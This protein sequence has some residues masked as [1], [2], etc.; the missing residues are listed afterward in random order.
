M[1]HD[2]ATARSAAA[3][4]FEAEDDFERSTRSTATS[5]A[6]ATDCRSCRP[7][8]SASSGCSPTAIARSTSRSRRW[9]RATAR[10]RRCGI[11]ANA[12]MAGC[13]PEYLPA[14]MA[15]IEAMCEEPFNLY[16][17]QA[18]TH[19][20]APLVDRQRSGRERAR[21]QL[22]P[23]RVRRRAIARNA[24][25]GRAVR[26]VCSTSAA[27][28][29]ASAT[30]RPSAHPPNTLLRRRER[31]RQPV[32]AAA[33]RARVPARCEHR[34]GCRRAK[35]RTTSTT[36]KASAAEGILKTI[37]GTVATTGDNDATL[38]RRPL[39]VFG[40]EHAATVAADG[41]SKADVKRSSTST[42]RFRL[43][44]FRDEYIERRLRASFRRRYVDAGPDARVTMC[45]CAEDLIIIVIGGAGKHSCLHSDFRQHAIGHARAEAPRRRLCALDSRA[46]RA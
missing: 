28:F 18:T 9:R 11:A 46:A 35:A 22:R 31:R 32:G 5:A 6:G 34:H 40:P 37:A 15:A 33:R 3:R 14:V 7:A 43:G 2:R 8:S 13:R 26:C 36:T 16:G 12:V 39:I 21:H 45:R 19:S 4:A 41:F 27:R 17:I 10:R 23:Q 24:T 44:T 42:R 1:S 25:I 38:R 30:C 20:C 29:P